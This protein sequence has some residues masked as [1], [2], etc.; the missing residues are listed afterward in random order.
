MR[1]NPKKGREATAPL[2][3]KEIQEVQ[4]GKKRY[5]MVVQ[6]SPKMP[7]WHHSALKAWSILAWILGSQVDQTKLMAFQVATVPTSTV[8]TLACWKIFLEEY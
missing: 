1:A 4:G 6:S 8:A 5:T 2:F 7:K 3:I